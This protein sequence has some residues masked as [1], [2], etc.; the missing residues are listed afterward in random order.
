[1]R[2][3]DWPIARKLA[4]LC[5]AFGLLPVAI[6][7]TVML[8]RATSSARENAA[9]QLRLSANHLADK[10]DRNLFERYGD[11]QAFG[12]ND[13]INDRSQWYKAGADKNLI[14]KKTNDYVAAYGMYKL[15]MLVDTT[16]KLVAVNDRNAAG[17]SIATTALYERSYA[18]ASWFKACKAGDFTRR[19]AFSDSGNTAANGTVITASAA[20]PDVAQ[21]YG[22]GAAEVVGFTAQVRDRSGAFIAC[23]HN[24]ATME[25]VTAMLGDAAREM[26]KAGYPSAIIFVVDSTGR[27]IATGGK[28]YSD[29]VTAVERKP[30][31]ALDA[32][33]QGRS[34]VHDATINGAD[35]RIGFT[36]LRGALGYPGMNWG[37]LLAVSE[38]EI[39]DV[40]HIGSTT[41]LSLAL[42]AVLAVGIIF[43]ALWIGG[44][45]A[46]PIRIMSEV[47]S[48]VAVGR[49]DCH[50]TWGMR[51]EIG[52][53]AKS[54]N[55]IVRSQKQLA[56]TARQLAKG[57]TQVST[58]LRSEHDEL[59]RAFTSLRNTL[60]ALVTEV[61]GLVS[62]AEQGRLSS[63]GK[64]SQFDGAFK[65]LVSG[66]NKTLD[67]ITTPV[68]EARVVLGKMAAGDLSA[69]VTGQYNGDHAALA[70]SL[71]SAAQD[72]GHALLEVRK[73]S[74]SILAATEQIAAA[75]QEQANSATQQASL[76]QTVTMEL[77]DQRARSAEVTTQ[78][79][80]LTKSVAATRDA[81]IQ[82]HRQVEDVATAL[83]RIRER[84]TATQRIARNIE[85]I[86]SQTNLLALNAAVEAA[87]AGDAGLGFAVVAAEVRALAL[88]ATE[89]A[90]ETQSVIDETMESVKDGE[91]L[92]ADAVEVLKSIQSQADK[93]STL[94][95][96]IARGTEAQE[97]GLVTIDTTA[98]SVADLTSSSAANA[99]ETA[100]ASEEMASLARTLSDLV[101]EFNLTDEAR[102]SV[103]AAARAPSHASR[104]TS[105]P[106]AARKATAP[107]RSAARR[108]ASVGASVAS[109]ADNADEAG[110]DPF[111]DF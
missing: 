74:H 73:E 89:S 29:S 59:G 107:T 17:Q 92:G 111:S 54:L 25:L 51:D 16:G 106:K 43:L 30:G 91:R 71:N 28:P 83:V 79:R 31:G 70:R 6:V 88:R 47:A 110:Q 20:D 77:A 2:L 66:F 35:T 9:E 104:E 87:R 57:D 98:T 72:L 45:I 7:S 5:L 68:A 96:D 94:V 21:V 80:D 103:I 1:M 60:G 14:A 37:V 32:L 82:G 41:R 67:A 10:V 52:M 49:T 39:D 42:T 78:T 38:S 34:G 95:V 84:A 93:A 15:A 53:V 56:E 65:S 26:T 81:A 62:D 58:E 33:V 101:G 4:L 8:R 46:T 100:A 44:R 108:T 23:W 99:E 36:H 55:Q 3:K 24:A 61:S 85:E 90:K 97:L 50:A 48:D 12:Y 27:T 64:P 13:V 63:R 102:P 11:V 105:R 40:A 86:A 109:D 18:E 22:A 69:R 19:M 75:S 76:L